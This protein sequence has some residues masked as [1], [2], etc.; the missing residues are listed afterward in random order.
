MNENI[1]ILFNGIIGYIVSLITLVRIQD[2]LGV[3]VAALTSVYLIVIIYLKLKKG[4][5]NETKRNKEKD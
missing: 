4:F 1:K 2:I 3:A 5:K